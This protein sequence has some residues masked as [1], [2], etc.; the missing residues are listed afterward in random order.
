MANRE[1]FQYDSRPHGRQIRLL[2]AEPRGDHGQDSSL[3]SVRLVEA[4][5][6]TAVF[7]ALSYVWGDQANHVYIT[8]NGKGHHVGQNLHAAR[9]EYRR[10]GQFGQGLWADAICINQGDDREKTD[11]VRMMRD[12]YSAASRTIIWLGPVEAGDVEAIQLA[13][14][15][16]K[17]CPEHLRYEEDGTWRLLSLFH[18]S[19]RGLPGAKVGSDI[20]P[21][22]RSLFKIL[23][24]PWFS[25]IW[26]VQELL[27]SRNPQMWRGGETIST[28][29]LLWM[30]N[31]VGEHAELQEAIYLSEGSISKFN[32]RNIAWCHRRFHKDKLDPLWVNMSRTMDMEAKLIL[33]RFFALAGISEGLPEDF[34]NYTKT[35]EEVGGSGWSHDPVR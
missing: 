27:L 34:V 12:V 3:L 25:R 17:K 5:L 16:Y 8:C 14:L 35:L 29:A 30:A 22:W 2:F 11:Q 1:P 32:A 21:T 15:A 24:H 19:D 7:D 23:L 10:R 28:A 31:Q 6:D 9:M 13:E 4:N 20:C 26:I 18:G 33:D